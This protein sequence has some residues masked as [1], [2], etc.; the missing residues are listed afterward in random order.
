MACG[1]NEKAGAFGLKEKPLEARRSL[2]LWGGAV[3]LGGGGAEL[4]LFLG[5][6]VSGLG[7]RRLGV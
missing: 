6:R 5:F 4:G 7:F 1:F 3:A 2:R